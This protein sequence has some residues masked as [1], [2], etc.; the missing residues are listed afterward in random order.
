[1]RLA[2]FVEAAYRDEANEITEVWD[3]DT[4]GGDTFGVPMGA[5]GVV[6]HYACNVLGDSDLRSQFA[7]VG[8]ATVYEITGKR[9]FKD[10]ADDLGV[11]WV[12]IE[13]T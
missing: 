3:S 9:T 13:P 5:A 1:L 7:A 4:G 10:A 2:I 6:T 8:W 11:E 12:D